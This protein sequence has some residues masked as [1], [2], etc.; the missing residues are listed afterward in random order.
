LRVFAEKLARGFFSID[1]F[2]SIDRLRAEGWTA[3]RDRWEYSHVVRAALAFV[4][5]GLLVTAV[6][7]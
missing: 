5:L 7:V 6:T 1:P 4:S 3:L 2:R